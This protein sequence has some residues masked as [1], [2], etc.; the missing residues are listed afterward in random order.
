MADVPAGTQEFVQPTHDGLHD[1]FFVLIWMFFYSL[2]DL[3]KG[4]RNFLHLDY[5]IRVGRAAYYMYYNHYAIDGKDDIEAA[6]SLLVLA[7]AYYAFNCFHNLA[8]KKWSS[9]HA[10]PLLLAAMALSHKLSPRIIAILGMFEISNVFMHMQSLG[11]HLGVIERDGYPNWGLTIVQVLAWIY[12]RLV[13]CLPL[14]TAASHRL[15]MSAMHKPLS[16]SASAPADNSTVYHA[17]FLSSAVV[18]LW[19]YHLLAAPSMIRKM[20]GPRSK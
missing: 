9:K 14:L 13:L 16:A 8:R 3:N 12:F 4:S 10:V 7:T 19:C 17:Y 5:S 15:F 18:Y 2:L 1:A 20:F 11:Q 6:H